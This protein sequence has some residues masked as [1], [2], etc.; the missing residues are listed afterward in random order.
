MSLCI[1]DFS[2]RNREVKTLAC[3][4]IRFE[5]SFYI[6]ILNIVFKVF[7]LE[8]MKLCPY[9]QRVKMCINLVALSPLCCCTHSICQTTIGC[10]FQY[11]Y[12]KLQAQGALFLPW[13]HVQTWLSCSHLYQ[14]LCSVFAK[15]LTI[16][17]QS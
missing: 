8:P 10:L 6:Y 15:E 7:G 16:I 3:S 4:V 9:D 12:T 13:Y 2:F 5:N 11:F 1:D 17:T 14:E